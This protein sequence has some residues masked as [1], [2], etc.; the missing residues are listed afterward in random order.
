M[1]SLVRYAENGI[2]THQMEALSHAEGISPEIIAERI[3]EGSIVIMQRDD[4]MTGIGAGLSTKINVNL[5]TSTGKVSV[6]DEIE[7]VRIAEMFGADTISDLSMGGDINAIR[8]AV[9][10]NST[11]PI[12][13]VPV[14][15]AAVENGLKEMTDDDIFA[16]LRRHADEGVSSIVVHCVNRAMLESFRK[17]KRILGMVSKGG[18]ITS[19]FM[20]INECENPFVERFDEVLSLCKKRDIVLSLGNTARSGCI[21]DCRDRMQL[22]ELRQ[23]IALAHRAHENGVQVIIEGC[24]GHIRSDRISKYV[25]QY[26]KQ[27]PFP[28]FVAGPLPTDIAAGYDHIAGCVGGSMASTAG[29]DYLCYITPAEHLGLPNPEAVKEGLIA[30]KI[31][32]HIGDTVKYGKDAKDK[33]IA[34]I[35]A[36]LDP[37]GQI[38]HALDPARA[39]AFSDEEDECTMCGE[40]CAIRIMRQY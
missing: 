25:K 35:R 31:A 32:A 39:Q 37:K 28:L 1:D 36:T 5:G 23:N 27:S 16:T 12:T 11:L 15:P 30:F 33:K 26:K 38:V 21:H 20:L 2:I 13:T 24:G 8:K 9:F 6:E 40:F 4:R 10:E 34:H 17:N 3:A 22:E 7:K 14:Y 19:A 29:A 18:S